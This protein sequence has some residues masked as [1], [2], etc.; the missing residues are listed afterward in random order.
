MFGIYPKSI[1]IVVND[2][3]VQ[4]AEIEIDDFLEKLYIPLTYWDLRD[5]KTSW[6]NSLEHGLTKRDHAALVVSMYEHKDFKIEKINNYIGPRNTHNEDGM[7]ISEWKT[8]IKSVM[9]FYEN[10]KSRTPLTPCD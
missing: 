9:D 4:P 1:P 6:F 8:D 2:E 7:K 3:W 5:Y 10:L